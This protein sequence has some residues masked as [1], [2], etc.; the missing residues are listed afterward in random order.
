MDPLSLFGNIYNTTTQLPLQYGGMYSQAYNPYFGYLGNQAGNMAG[1]GNNYMGQVGQMGQ[2][3]M[4]LYGQ[5]AGQE[6][7]MYGAELPYQQFNALAPVLSGLL[8]QGGM[9]LPAIQPMTFNRPDVMR[10]YQ[11]AVDRGYNEL[12]GAYGSSVN[13]TRSYDDTMSN[14]FADMM[15]KM[16]RAPYMNQGSGPPPRQP[17]NSGA[18]P[19]FP[20]GGIGQQRRRPY[21]PFASH[22]S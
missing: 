1:L 12:G 20:A 9:N 16:P 11:S 4:Q 21:Q 7:Q 18:T 17:R 2:Q 15:D 3:G 13:N 22:L 19:G 6:A 5:L 14:S 8:S 10:G